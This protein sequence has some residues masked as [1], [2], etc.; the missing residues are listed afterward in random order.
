[1]EMTSLRDSFKLHRVCRKAM[2]LQYGKINC[3]ESKKR[4]CF[5]HITTGQS[6]TQALCSPFAPSWLINHTSKEPVRGMKAEVSLRVSVYM[7]AHRTNSAKG[8]VHK[9]LVY[10]YTYNVDQYIYDIRERD[11]LRSL[12]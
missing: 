5:H 7:R 8:T 2:N 1:M 4:V 9:Q 3:T 6:F 12:L 10:T 11:A